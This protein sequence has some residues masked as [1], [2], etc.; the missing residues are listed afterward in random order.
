M[1]IQ[2]RLAI[3]LWVVVV[4]TSAETILRTRTQTFDEEHP[5]LVLPDTNRWKSLNRSSLPWL[6]RIIPCF[7]PLFYR[8]HL[9]RKSFPPQNNILLKIIDLISKIENLHFVVIVPL[10]RVVMILKYWQTAWFE[11]EKVTDIQKRRILTKSRVVA[12]AK[13]C[14]RNTKTQIT[15]WFKLA[16]FCV[17]DLNP[18]YIQ[19]LCSL[20]CELE[21]RLLFAQV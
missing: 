5:M 7:L 3:E 21:A 12:V 13:P 6:H 1:N 19:Q 11:D 14:S 9:F 15:S 16:T 4:N 20:I 2:Q 18:P 10:R 8:D 17:S